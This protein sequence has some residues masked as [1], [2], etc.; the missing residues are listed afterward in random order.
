MARRCRRLLWAVL[1]AED[2]VHSFCQ[3]TRERQ[4]WLRRRSLV[5]TGRMK[6]RQNEISAEIVEN[7][8]GGTSAVADRTPATLS[9]K[10]R[11]N[12]SAPISSGGG[13]RPRPSRASIELQSWRG[14]DFSA[15]I[16][17]RQ[18][19]SRSKCGFVCMCMGFICVLT[20]WASIRDLVFIRGRHLF[21]TKL[22]VLRYPPTC[23]RRPLLLHFRSFLQWCNFF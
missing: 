14:V 19:C 10:K 18:N 1:S 21:E 23:S 22:E 7:D 20:V 3:A 11:W 13:A 9:S 12:C 15:S 2:Q 6:Y 4:Q 16:F 5:E 17:S 8:G